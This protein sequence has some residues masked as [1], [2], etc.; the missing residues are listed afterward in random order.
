VVKVS[1]QDVTQ[2]MVVSRD[3]TGQNGALLLPKGMTLGEEHIRTMRAFGV[4]AVDIVSDEPEPDRD[5]EA[6]EALETT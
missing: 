2:G 5:D 1:I 6:L 4:H 3:V